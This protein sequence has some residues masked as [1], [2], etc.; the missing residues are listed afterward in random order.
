MTMLDTPPI[1][2]PYPYFGGKSKIADTVWERLGDTP[3]YIEPFAGSLAVLLARPQQTAD[4]ARVE[5]VNDLDGYICNFW[6]A[7]QADPEEVARYADYPVIELD[8][9]ARNTYLINLR[10]SFTERLRADPTFFDSKI[11]AWWVWGISAWIGGGWASAAKTQLPHLGDAGMGVHRSSLNGLTD[12]F[13]QLS[14]RVRR[15]RVCTGDWTRVTGDSVT[16]RNGVTAVFLDPPYGV[17]TG[18]DMNLYAKESHTVADEVRAWCLERGQNPM[19]RI[20]LC[21]YDTEHEELEWHDWTVETWN[22]GKGFAGRNKG[23]ENGK[24]E[25]IWYSPHCLKPFD[26]GLFQ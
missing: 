5:T 3:N 14:D 9:H 13:L 15:V 7:I 6:R 22:A 4:T 19:Y 11:A 16:I 2:S 17:S 8:L 26:G 24:R 21:G 18:R 20:A 12:Y 1:K 25:R 10:E 23:N